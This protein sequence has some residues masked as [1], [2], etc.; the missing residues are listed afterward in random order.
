M[1]EFVGQT[2]VLRFEFE[3]TWDWLDLIPQ[4]CTVAASTQSGSM[5]CHPS[6]GGGITLALGVDGISAL[7]VML[8]GIVMFTGVLVSWNITHRSKNFFILYFLLLSGVFGVFVSLDLFFL[9]F[10]YELAVLPMYLL[11]GVWGSSSDFRTL[12]TH[13]RST[14]R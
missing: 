2:H 7:M 3:R 11:I 12:R 14:G 5:D 10:F 8:T 6:I 4:E 13:Q 9:F 1:D